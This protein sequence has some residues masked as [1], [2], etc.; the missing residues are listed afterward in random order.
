MLQSFVAF[1]TS[2]SY[3]VYILISVED[4]RSKLQELDTLQEN[5][6]AQSSE[7][8]GKLDQALNV[9]EKFHN[10]YN[11]VT[12]SLRD[13]QDN[14]ISQDSPGIDAA[15]IIEQQKELAVSIQCYKLENLPVNIPLK[16]IYKYFKPIM[17]S[18]K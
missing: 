7:R 18:Q 16:Y 13:V 6:K 14:L 12:R 11:D 8:S 10:D 17:K 4:L 2:K 3:N 15:T 1:K 9:A 5:I